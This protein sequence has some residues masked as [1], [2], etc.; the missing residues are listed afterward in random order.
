MTMTYDQASAFLDDAIEKLRRTILDL[1]DVLDEVED[2]FEQ[3]QDADCVGDPAQFVP[4]EEMRLLM[5]IRRA[6]G[7]RE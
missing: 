3:R 7:V 1:A 4:N 6:R 5:M 2:Y